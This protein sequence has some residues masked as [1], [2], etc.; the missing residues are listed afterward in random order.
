M[1]SA[2]H[3]AVLWLSLTCVLFGT[4]CL[5]DPEQAQNPDNETGDTADAIG[6]FSSS[7]FQFTVL[8]SDDGMGRGGGWQVATTTL[9][10]RDFEYVT[11]P[12]SWE[13]RITVGMPIRSTTNGIILPEDAAAISAARATFASSMVRRQ[14]EWPVKELFCRAFAVEM[15]RGLRLYEPGATVTK[16]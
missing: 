3:V 8:V 4:G 9:K 14:A 12:K 16:V 15:E 7:L 11:D 6:G 5:L 10:F 13:C 2:H 1:R